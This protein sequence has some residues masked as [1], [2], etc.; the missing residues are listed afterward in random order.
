M[1]RFADWCWNSA[2]ATD[3]SNAGGR[4]VRPS[5]DAEL[6]ALFVERDLLHASPAVRPRDQPAVLS[7]EPLG[8]NG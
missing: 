4:R 7:M 6:L 3:P 1:T 2:C 5:V 8:R